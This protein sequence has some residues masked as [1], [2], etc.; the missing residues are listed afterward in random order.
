MV[1]T[2]YMEADESHQKR[3]KGLQTKN[4]GRQRKRHE[5]VELIPYDGKRYLRQ[6]AISASFPSGNDECHFKIMSPFELNTEV[7]CSI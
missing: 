7:S 2:T 4:E 3:G 1:V 5:R 6:H